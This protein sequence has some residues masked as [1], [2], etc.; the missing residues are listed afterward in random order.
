[1]IKI[2]IL[3]ENFIYLFFKLF[4]TRNKILFLSRQSNIITLDYKKIIK[5]LDN[6]YKIKVICRKLDFNIIGILKT[7]F[8]LFQQ[9]YHLATSKIVITDG[10]SISVS[11]LKHKKKL[12][13]IQMWHAEVVV[14]KIGLQTLPYISKKRKKLCKAMKMH[15]NYDYAIASSKKMGQVFSEAFNTDNIKILGTPTLDYIYNKE[16]KDK[17]EKIIKKYDLDKKKN[18]LYMPTYRKDS[19]ID[20]TDIINNFDFNNY[21]LILK[22][23]PVQKYT[24]IDDRVVNITKLK[25]EELLSI[26]DYIISDYS[27]VAFQAALAR[28][29][30][31]FYVYDIKHYK[32]IIGFNIDLVKEFPKYTSE[33]INVI[34]NNIY[35]EKYDYSYLDA[36]TKDYIECYDGKATKRIVEFIKELM[37]MIK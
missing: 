36:L 35:K 22:L 10:Y 14:K 19:Y 15:E 29:P 8:G 9:M 5:E 16:Y 1:M 17:K 23:H 27:N 18:I 25:S 24:T 30:T 33:D 34:L 3:L 21:N 7:T 28:I 32:K 6:K 4:P 20:L 31:Y 12:T 2:G 37:R 11:T 26:A 13:I